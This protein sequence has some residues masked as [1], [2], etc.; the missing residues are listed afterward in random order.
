MR[1]HLLKITVSESEMQLKPF[2][3]DVRMNVTIDEQPFACDLAV[4][5]SNVS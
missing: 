1:Q 4:A 5:V 3:T 2:E